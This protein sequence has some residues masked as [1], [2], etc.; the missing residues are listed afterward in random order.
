MG[1]LLPAGVPRNV[2]GI[3]LGKDR[4]I[5]AMAAPRLDRAPGSLVLTHAL[6]A[7]CHDTMGDLIDDVAEADHAIAR[8][9][10]TGLP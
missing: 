3:V 6:S 1:I 4:A 9:P 5:T 10:R 7:N 2:G 8:P